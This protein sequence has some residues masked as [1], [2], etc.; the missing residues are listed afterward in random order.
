MSQKQLLTLGKVAAEV[1][2]PLHTVEYIVRSRGIKEAAR[3]G[4]LR[5][6]APDVVEQ[7]QGFLRKRKELHRCSA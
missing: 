1:G 3:A 7:V 4:R 2:A 6:F 5:V